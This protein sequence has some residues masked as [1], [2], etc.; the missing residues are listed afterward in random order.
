MGVW[1]SY[2]V[3]RAY[4]CLYELLYELWILFADVI[5]CVIDGTQQIE[6]IK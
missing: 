4:E 6:Y 1:V 3:M 5:A 2:A